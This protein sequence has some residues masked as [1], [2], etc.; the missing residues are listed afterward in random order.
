MKIATGKRY[1]MFAVDSEDRIV[2]DQEYD[3][4]PKVG[5]I[6]TFFAD[7]FDGDYSDDLFEEV[8]AYRIIIALIEDDDAD[9]DTDGGADD[10]NDNEINK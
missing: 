8:M 3:D 6:L 2:A 7:N 9:D 5:D 4:I 10:S 1:I